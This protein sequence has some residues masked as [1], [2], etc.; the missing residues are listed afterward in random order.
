MSDPLEGL[1]DHTDDVGPAI[2]DLKDGVILGV[3]TEF[4]WERT[5]DPVLALL[6]VS[7]RTAEGETF[8]FAFD[9]L[10]VDVRPVVEFLCESDCV[11]IFHAGRIDL[12]ILNGLAPRLIEPVFDTQRA[13]SLCGLGGQVGYANLIQA[14][15]GQKITK[16]EQYAD[17]TKRPLRPAQLDYALADVLPLLDAH[18]ALVEQLKESGRTEWAVEEVS[19]LTDPASY[20]KVPADERYLKVKGTRAV[21]RRGLGILRELA[22]WREA[23]AERRDLRPGFVFKDP[24]L[25]DLAR[26]APTRSQDL[27][28]VRG[29]HRGEIKRNGDAILKA[30][31]RG[32]DLPESELPDK[33]KRGNH[34][35]VGGVLDLLKAFLGQRSEELG[36]AS[37][38]VATSGDLE[39]LAKDEK[40]ER[41]AKDHR[42]LQGWRGELI[43]EDLCKILRGE[44][45]LAVD[46]EQPGRV[47]LFQL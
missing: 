36:I 46:P 26:R 29:L 30:I 31:K 15:V 38:T 32:L 8:A 13:A 9:P 7:A 47:K 43:G 3:D 14:L 22:A 34:K 2:E 33:K 41:F 5:Y 4:F 42:I 28:Q 11:K 18:K 19:D 37:E 16:T 27:S 39:R 25:I 35:R 21:D 12:E 17:W 24:V 44:V 23:E 6:Q 20:R 1:V 40:R 45:R 10:R